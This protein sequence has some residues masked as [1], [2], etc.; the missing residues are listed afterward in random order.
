MDGAK[1]R[2]LEQLIRYRIKKIVATDDPLLTLTATRMRRLFDTVK[3]NRDHSD[4]LVRLVQ[5]GVTPTDIICR[6]TSVFAYAKW[7]DPDALTESKYMMAQCGRRLWLPVIKLRPSEKRSPRKSAAMV[8]ALLTECGD[9]VTAL[10]ASI[11]R[12]KPRKGNPHAR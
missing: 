3:R 8:A 7:H 12:P 11:K 9:L 4:Y 1:L 10:V 5:S 6:I 2:S